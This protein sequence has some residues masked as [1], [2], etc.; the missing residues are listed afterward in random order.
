MNH[1]PITNR[2]AR[3]YIDKFMDGATSNA[4]EQALYAYFRTHNVPQ[5]LQP[6][7]EMFAYYEA[8]M[9][10]ELLPAPVPLSEARPR[11][12]KLWRFASMAAAACLLAWIGFAGK[13]YYDWQEFVHTYE[14]SYMIVKGKRVED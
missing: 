5:E 11:R 8:G 13:R 6:Y 7:R 10:D 3:Q 9:P 4:E 14:G 12:R 2:T 1:I